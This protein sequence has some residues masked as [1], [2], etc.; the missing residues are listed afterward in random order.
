VYAGLVDGLSVS[1][2]HGRSWQ[3]AADLAARRLVWYVPQTAERWLAA[4]PEEGVWQTA[5][6]GRTWQMIWQEVPVLAVAA[7]AEQI[8]LSTEAGIVTTADNGATWQMAWEYE[9]PLPA[10]AVLGDRVWVGSG[11]GQV[12]RGTRGEWQAVTVPF[13]GQHLIGFLVV[14]AVLLAVVWGDNRL[15]LWRRDEVDDWTLWFSQAAGAVLPHVA[16][17]GEEAIVGL[18]SYIYR[19]T[20]NGWQRQRV[21]SGDAPVTAVCAV[22]SGGWL[23]AVTDALLQS[24]DGV[25][26]APVAN[27]LRGEAVVSLVAAAGQL[28]AGTADGKVWVSES[29]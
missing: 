27:G 23:T 20:D 9:E 29:E 18:G 6:G 5:D 17:R 24:A 1:S 16:I 28:L 10:L 8:W 7:T 13:A 11:D 26:W 4:G 22:S 21:A 19:R 25:H 15:Q 2:D 12:W 3:A 14:E